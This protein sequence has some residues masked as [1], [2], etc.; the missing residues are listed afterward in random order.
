MAIN[1]RNYG[2]SGP[3]N[4]QYEEQRSSSPV[5][6]KTLNLGKVFGIMFIWLIFTAGIAFLG[7]FLF[8]KWLVAAPE[9]ASNGLMV[10]LIVSGI[11]LIVL[12]CNTY[13]FF[14]EGNAWAC[15]GHDT[16]GTEFHS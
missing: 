16:F 3:N 10:S 8:A 1:G 2:T 9:Q 11:S 15:V 7:G 4:I 5:S 14:I 13:T 6:S 12:T